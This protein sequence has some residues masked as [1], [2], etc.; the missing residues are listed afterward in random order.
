MA[1]I[2]NRH[3]QTVSLVTAQFDRFA[4]DSIVKVTCVFAVNRYQRNIAQINAVF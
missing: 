1:D 2:S 4:I 3:Q